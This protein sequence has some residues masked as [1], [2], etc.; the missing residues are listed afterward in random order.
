MEHLSIHVPQTAPPALG[1]GI[2]PGDRSSV[3]GSWVAVPW[4]G[5][6]AWA[7]L[8]LPGQQRALLFIPALILSIH[9]EEAQH[10]EV[11]EGS[12]HRQACQDVN[13]AEGHV[14]RVILKCV[15]LLQCD[16]VAETYGGERDEAVVV[17]MEEAP[18]LVSRE[19]NGSDTQCAHAGKK[20][21]GDHIGH[22]DFC[23]PHAQALLGFVQQEADEGVDSL[24]H[25]LE[26]DQCQ[27][28]PQE[29]V[30]HAERL[31]GIC[32]WGRMAITLEINK[33]DRW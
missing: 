28:D 31:P 2:H 26:H 29:G 8:L 23:V 1:P 16:V 22:G 9:G 5:A 24:T 33:T 4:D 11:E 15:V 18:A 10:Y 32:A 13:K 14:V 3:A 30:T 19:G 20:A 21:N 17:G 6:R 12:Y 27:G 25:T 7:P